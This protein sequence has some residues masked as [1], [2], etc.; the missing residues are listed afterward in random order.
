MHCLLSLPNPVNHSLGNSLAHAA[1]SKFNSN[2]VVLFIVDLRQY[3]FRLVDTVDDQT[4]DC[5]PRAAVLDR[6]M[7]K[8][9]AI[10]VMNFERRPVARRAWREAELFIHFE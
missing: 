9:V 2:F 10:T 5:R 4:L 1:L 8:R 3:V 7:I 6:N